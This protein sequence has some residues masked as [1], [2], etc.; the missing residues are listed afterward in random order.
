MLKNRT[1][2]TP[3]I[4][5]GITAGAYAAGDVVGGLIIFDFKEMFG[6]TLRSIKII[7]VAEQDEAFK[8]YLFDRQPTTIDDNDPFT[9][10]LSD[11]QKWVGTITVSAS[12][13]E[14]LNNIAGADSDSWAIDFASSGGLL[15]AYFVTT[16]TPTYAAATDLSIRAYAW[17]D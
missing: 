7:D 10:S 4:T 13:Y 17:M 6:G 15:Y 2:A 8:V 16:G 3:V 9:L 14:S 11:W 1:R 12:D 5:P